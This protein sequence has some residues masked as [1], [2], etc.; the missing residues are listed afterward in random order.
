MS[1]KLYDDADWLERKYW[2]EG[3][4]QREI[5]ELAG[6][7]KGIISKFM[8]KH[9]IET[10]SSAESR[11]FREEKPHDSREWLVR[12]YVDD[13]MTL[14]EIADEAG[15]TTGTV[16]NR[17]QDFDIETRGRHEKRV[18][19]EFENL[20]NEEWLRQKYEVEKLGMG[21][22][23]N[24]A[25]SSRTAVRRRLKKFNIDIRT[26]SQAN[27]AA[28]T[29]QSSPLRNPEWL[30]DRYNAQRL[31][32]PE[33]ADELDV[34]P[35]KVG[36][37]MERHGIKR[38][39]LSVSNRMAKLG[40]AYD[41]FEN[42]EWLREEYLNKERS[43]QDIA[44]DFDVTSTAVLYAL[45][46]ADISRR[47]H[48]EVTELRVGEGYK[49]LKDDEWMETQYQIRERSTYDIAEELDVAHGTVTRQLERIGIP[50]RG[51]KAYIEHLDHHVRSEWELAIADMLVDIG[52]Q[53]EYEPDKI[54]I[55]DGV[56]Y[57]PDFVTEEFII[58]VKGKLYEADEYFKAERMME[59]FP[60]KQYVVI[61]LE[62]PAD[63]HIPWEERHT[64]R[65]K[66]RPDTVRD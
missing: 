47:D 36:I 38:R 42:P 61:G 12:R 17:F 58:E 46:R 18:S 54:D 9:E 40:E 39:D 20:N 27:I 11:H 3:L 6:V 34:T 59:M 30:H 64:L 48:E 50:R 8:R 25:N 51:G 41:Y 49:L 62:L 37:W 57:I 44:K 15:V 45:E 5:G 29:D 55:G 10:R 33:I 32:T 13:R 23:A 56:N 2:D 24:E 26:V 19:E 35:A 16:Y 66:L 63:I 43:C 31:S 22:I 65:N 1:N 14:S 60:N 7:T 4:T 28:N 21:T 52:I 53:Y